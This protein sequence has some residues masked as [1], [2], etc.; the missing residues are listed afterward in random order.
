MNGGKDIG[1]LHEQMPQLDQFTYLTQFVWLCVLFSTFYVLLYEGG[2]LK[3]SRIL[4]LRKQLISLGGLAQSES[5]VGQNVVVFFSECFNTS[6]SYLYS[7][8]YGADQWY[9]LQFKILNWKLLRM[10][11]S[12]VCSSAEMSFSQVLKKHTLETLVPK[13]FHTSPAF[14]PRSAA[15]AYTS[16]VV[17]HAQIN[18]IESQ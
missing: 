7:S 17:L 18:T 2:L 14:P 6:V 16:F 1:R 9:N 3:I 4:K 8:F 11:V 12:Y 13:S 10:T 15:A 5:G